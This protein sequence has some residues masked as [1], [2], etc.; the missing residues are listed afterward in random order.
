MNK[1]IFVLSIAALFCCS[2][3][4]HSKN[5]PISQGS[6]DGVYLSARSMAMGGAGAALSK[7]REFFYSNA[8]SLADKEGSYYELSFI[9]I[10]ENESNIPVNTGINSVFLS[11]NSASLLWRRMSQTSLVKNSDDKISFSINAL[12]LSSAKETDKNISVGWSLSYI[13]GNLS[14]ASYNSIEGAQTSISGGNGFSFDL[15]FLTPLRHNFSLGLNLKNIAGFMFY[16]G[17]EY[18][19]LPF[20]FLLGL[21]YENNGFSAAIDWDKRFYKYS[22]LESGFLRAGIEQGI[23]D[24][25]F[26]RAGVVSDFD[27]KKDGFKYSGGLSFR[28]KKLYEISMAGERQSSNGAFYYMLSI[29]AAIKK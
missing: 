20:S 23:N 4:A 24:F 8:A 19:R 11:F 27:F 10:I 16:S 9:P 3:K 29:S 12:S 14:Q 13:Y 5:V 22:D 1:K 25:L 28:I 21:G 7:N 2:L 15:S 26:L 6:Y 18:Q 17:Y